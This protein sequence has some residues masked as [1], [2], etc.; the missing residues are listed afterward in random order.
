MRGC[1]GKRN[2]KN[3]IK[4]ILF[5]VFLLAIFCFGLNLVQADYSASSV[6][7]R[8]IALDA[9]HGGDDPGAIN[10]NYEVTEKDVNLA[11][12]KE[13]QA[14]LTEAGACVVLTREGDETILSRKK[15]VE[16]A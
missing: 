6:T 12:V 11:V 2:N 8:I 10:K 5:A 14:Q 15:R 16:I 9:G 3:M 4:K 7:G 13:L 1:C